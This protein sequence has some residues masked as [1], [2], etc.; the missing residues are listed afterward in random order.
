MGH[1]ANKCPLKKPSGKDSVQVEESYEEVSYHV[2]GA[3]Q[4]VVFN[5]THEVS[6]LHLIHESR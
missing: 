5:T 3:W 1:Y 2:N 4:S 6:V